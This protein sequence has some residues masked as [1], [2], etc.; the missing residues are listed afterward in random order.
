MLIDIEKFFEKFEI[1][2]NGFVQVGAHLGTEVEKFQK[3]NKNAHIY[4]FEPQEK[5]YKKLVKKFQKNNLIKVLNTGL[6][7]VENNL[8]MYKDLNNESQ[9]S[10]FLKPKDHLKYHSYINFTLDEKEVI[11]IMK[12]DSYKINDANILCVDVQGFEL[13]VLKGGERFIE[14]CDAILIEVNRKE[15][16]EGCPHINDIDKFLKNF[17]FIR[18]STKWW[19][20]TIPWGDALY[21]KKNKVP[22]INRLSLVF[23]NYINT[24]TLTFFI[25]SRFI[26]IKNFKNKT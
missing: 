18:V 15:L 3:I 5:F 6:G 17:N 14:N 2:V 26:N 12:L 21:L 16:Y 24:K 13:K 1:K 20:Q 22:F 8:T 25:L 9:S 10:S 11:Q 4:L 23:K 7:D 19:K